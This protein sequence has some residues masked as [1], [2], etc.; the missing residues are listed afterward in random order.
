MVR[1]RYPHRSHSCRREHNGRGS[2]VGRVL[3]AP[4]PPDEEAVRWYGTILVMP[5]CMCRTPSGRGHER[6]GQGR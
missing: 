2:S 3:L 4:I 1:G 6:W 5:C